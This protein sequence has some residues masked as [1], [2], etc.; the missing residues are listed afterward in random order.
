MAPPGN[1]ITGSTIVDPIPKMPGNYNDATVWV[2]PVNIN[3]AVNKIYAAAQSIAADLKALFDCL[4][5]L[6]LSWGGDASSKA[7]D[8]S[9]QLRSLIDELFGVAHPLPTVGA[10]GTLI[11]GVGG[12]AQAYAGTEQNV[13]NMFN[14]MYNN[15]VNPPPP[16][17]E[18]ITFEV[19]GQWYSI[20]FPVTTTGYTPFTDNG[21][22]KP[23]YSTSVNET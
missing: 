8:L 5:G 15:L 6:K 3:D 11:N 4:N 1:G 17:T 9:N 7:Q 10:L 23:Y 2:T 22:D 12:I 14:G 19:N 21:T 18:T 16:P 20:T 13:Y